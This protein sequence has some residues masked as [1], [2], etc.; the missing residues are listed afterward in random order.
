M[1]VMFV[2]RASPHVLI[3][4]TCE[5]IPVATNIMVKTNS[6]NVLNSHISAGRKLS[7]VEIINL[8]H[9]IIYL[10][11]NNVSSNILGLHI[12]LS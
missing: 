12:N 10:G 6:N 8:G 9:F 7:I 2:L 1:G 4:D 5:V 3:M 11:E